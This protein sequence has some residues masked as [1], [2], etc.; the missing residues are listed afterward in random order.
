MTHMPDELTPASIKRF[1]EHMIRRHP[2]ERGDGP[3]VQQNSRWHTLDD[4]GLNISLTVG[5]TGARVFIRAG[6]TT[7]AESSKKASLT[8]KRLASRQAELE[9]ALGVPME[10]AETGYFFAD[11]LELDLRDETNWDSAADWLFDRSQLYETA[12]RDNLRK[13]R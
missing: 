13:S 1:W 8:G 10:T 5:D 6:E 3:P 12:L 2:A 9:N 4:L 7:K 11:R